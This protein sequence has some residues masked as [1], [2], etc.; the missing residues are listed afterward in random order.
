MSETEG[1]LRRLPEIDYAHPGIDRH[2]A[3]SG[4]IEHMKLL[5]L[6][7]V[8]VRWLPDAEEGYLRAE[9][10]PGNSDWRRRL[11]AAELDMEASPGPSVRY[12]TRG[13]LWPVAWRPFEDRARLAAQQGVW[14]RTLRQNLATA[15]TAA[16]GAVRALGY[17]A[18][19]DSARSRLERVACERGLALWAPV[20][21]A[22][23]AGLWLYWVLHQE[24]V[25]VPRPALRVVDASLH[26][27]DGPAVAWPG[28]AH[29]YFW[30]GIQ[31]P[32]HFI[33]EPDRLNPRRILEERNQELQRVMLERLGYDR[34]I[35]E[36]GAVPVQ[37]DEFGALYR[38][39]RQYREPFALVHVTNSTPEPDGSRK[40]YFLRVP[41]D[42][43]TAREAVAWTF[44]LP[45]DEYRPTQET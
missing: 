34:F 44:G 7:P 19:Q 33:A 42:V 35:L 18:A 15:W 30:R 5:G 27:P 43:K 2:R 10:G 8:R 32:E 9:R 16:G 12:L 22:F 6:E 21:E 29:Y 38:V 23:R 4:L 24:V 36:L 25:A 17:L 45:A 41:P 14:R 37:A 31:V 1:L 11:Q 20:L 3:A 40:R 13:A 39:R 28:G 26:A